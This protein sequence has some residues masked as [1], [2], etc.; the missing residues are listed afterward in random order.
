MR[1][2]NFGVDDFERFHPGG[3]LGRS[4]RMTVRD[5]MHGRDEIAWAHPEDSLKQVVIAMT[6]YPHG[7]AC[8]VDSEHRLRG[9]SPMA[10]FAGRC[11]LT[12]IFADCPLQPS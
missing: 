10:M 1:A 12:M 7:A 6:H 4:L 9:L 3:H 8:V 2:R 11:K 5:V